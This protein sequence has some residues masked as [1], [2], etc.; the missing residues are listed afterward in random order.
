[1]SGSARSESM[2]GRMR[3]SQPAYRRSAVVHLSLR[4]GDGLLSALVKASACGGRKGTPVQGEKQVLQ[5]IHLSVYDPSQLECVR[6][7]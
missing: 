4:A 2:S 7:G 1:M 6:N 3:R 5:C